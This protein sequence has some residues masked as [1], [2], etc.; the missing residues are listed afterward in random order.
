MSQKHLG[1]YPKEQQI[2]LDHGTN[3]RAM[4]ETG[5]PQASASSMELEHILCST[6]TY[7]T[8]KI[9]LNICNLLLRFGNIQ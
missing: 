1:A 5:G 8:R 9:L 3:T 2:P 6:E 4:T 7:N